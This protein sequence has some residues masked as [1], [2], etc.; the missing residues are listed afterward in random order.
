MATRKLTF[1][2]V[3]RWNNEECRDFLARM[4]WPNGP[5]CPN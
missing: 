3:L 4:R 5:V 1:Q 2:S